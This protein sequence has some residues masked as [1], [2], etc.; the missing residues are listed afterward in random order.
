[1]NSDRDRIESAGVS[2]VTFRTRL[3]QAWDVGL[4]ADITLMDGTE[5]S[6]LLIEMSSTALILDRWDEFLNAPAGD[7]F[8]LEFREVTEVVIP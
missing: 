8:T 2:D 3:E 1:V 4:V 5:C 6:A 7:P